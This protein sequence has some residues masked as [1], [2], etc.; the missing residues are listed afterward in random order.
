MFFYYLYKT[1]DRVILS[2]D[3]EYINLYMKNMDAD[4]TEEL[5]QDKI[6]E[7]GKIVSLFVT[8]DETDSSKGFGFDKFE[9]TLNNEKNDNK[10]ETQ[11]NER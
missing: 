2:A 3:V 4:I 9:K 10:V 8:K 5:L 7:F 6:Y 11:R 1:T